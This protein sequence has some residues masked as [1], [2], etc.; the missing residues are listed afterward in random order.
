MD[1]ALTDEESRRKYFAEKGS[2]SAVDENGQLII[3]NDL[4]IALLMLY[5][6]ILYTGSSYVYALS[7]SIDSDEDNITNLPLQ[8]I[9][10]G[11]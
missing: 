5:G 4:D 7:M 10:C 8:I 6:H 2:Y 3:N 1:F 9:S 11:R